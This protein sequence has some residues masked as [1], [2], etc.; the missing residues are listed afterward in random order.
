M[1]IGLSPGPTS[2]I[3][4]T[5]TAAVISAGGGAGPRFSLDN[6]NFDGST[7]LS[8]TAPGLSGMSDGKQWAFS[9]WFKMADDADEVTNVVFTIRA[10]SSNKFLLQRSPTAQSNR[11]TLVGRNVGGTNILYI[12]TNSGFTSVLNSGWNHMLC[13]GNLATGARHIYINDSS[14]IITNNFV[15]DTLDFT[16]SFEIGRSAEIT[17]LPFY[18]SMAE[19]WMDDSYIDF[20]VEANRRKFYSAAGAAVD[21]GSDGSTPTG[22]SPLMYLHLDADEAAANFALNAG[23][24]G[25]LT[26]SAGSL[27]STGDAPTGAVISGPPSYTV[28]L[29]MN[30]EDAGA[31]TFTNSGSG[32][33][34]TQEGSGIT[35]STEQV[36]FGTKSGKFTAANGNRL[37]VDNSG[38]ELE[39]LVAQDW[40]LEFFV[41][42]NTINAA[43]SSTTPD[44]QY[45]F[46]GSSL[47]RLRNTNEA[48]VTQPGFQIPGHSATNMPGLSAITQQTWHHFALVNEANVNNR[49]YID[50]TL[51]ATGS[52]GTFANGSTDLRIGNWKDG[53]GPYGFNGYFDSI[54]LTAGWF[55]YSGSSFTVPASALTDDS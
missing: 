45:M 51:I 6:A 7:T 39:S 33:S 44:N 26:I 9:L 8:R 17:H 13:S 49:F 46:E 21:L 38:G 29:L 50:G 27:T 22:S 16:G 54:R 47:V 10:N 15:N 20:S 11:M 34:I 18:G 28:P 36:K 37:R 53:S 2:S 12:E 30:F 31:T 14:D 55:R 1:K 43:D 42:F 4:T 5:Q 25:D 3:I 40:C 24:G 23:T 35:N 48:G 19:F 41:F 32:G 52:N